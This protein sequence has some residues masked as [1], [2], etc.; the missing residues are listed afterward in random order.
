[1]AKRKRRAFTTDRGSQYAS[2]DDQRVLGQHGQVCGMSRRGN[3]WDN[4]VAE[5]FF[6]TL[7]V[8]LVHDATWATRTAARTELFDYLEPFYNG[9]GGIPRSV[10]SVPGP[11]SSGTAPKRWQANPSAYETGASLGCYR[12]GPD[13]MPYWHHNGHRSPGAAYSLAR[14]QIEKGPLWARKNP[15]RFGACGLPAQSLSIARPACSR[16]SLTGRPRARGPRELP[17]DTCAK[18][19]RGSEDRSECLSPHRP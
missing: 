12:F 9:S 5:N 7:K 16:F 2:G 6:A 19:G 11:S 8:E 17:H 18:S 13:W 3:C 10:S 14:S 1:M 4:A 15:G